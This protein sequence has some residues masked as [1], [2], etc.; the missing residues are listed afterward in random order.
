MKNVILKKTIYVFLAFS[1]AVTVACQS[2]KESAARA[3]K[4]A[5]A[6]DSY[7]F[8]RVKQGQEIEHVLKFK[9]DGD[10]ALILRKAKGSKGFKA[11][12]VTTAAVPPGGE[13]E[14][15]VLFKTKSRIGKTSGKV[16]VESNDEA[17][18]KLA[19]PVQVEVFAD[20]AAKPK[21]ISF[22][23]LGKDEK[24]VRELEVTV[25]EPDKIKVRSVKT[26]DP[27]FA[28]A[29]KEGDPNGTA[30][31]EIAFQGS[32]KIERIID[33]IVIEYEGGDEASME[34]PCNATIEGDLL[35]PKT[36]YFNKREG[37]YGPREISIS[38]RTGK[39]VEVKRV[40]DDDNML[41]SSVKTAKGPNAV[42]VVEVADPGGSY[43]EGDRHILKIHTTDAEQ[44]IVEIGY[45]ISEREMRSKKSK[46]KNKLRGHNKGAPSDRK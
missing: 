42:V 2:K 20:V 45:K 5:A 37:V 18:P 6:E 30:K 4:I 32:E 31:Y 23:R 1:L 46:S 36:L 25:F 12:I 27:R 13:A 24:T 41:K 26:S 10:D 39:T 28:V 22:G 29:L 7:D 44:P 35:Y 43:S 34:I 16:T 19:V 17:N 11:E 40:E 8:G 14:V 15:K 3:P 21:T 38:S 9:N 33:K